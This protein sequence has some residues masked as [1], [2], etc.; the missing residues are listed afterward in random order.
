MQQSFAKY[1]PSLQFIVG[2]HQADSITLTTKQAASN[3]PWA[4]ALPHKLAAR[5]LD[6][7]RHIHFAS[8]LALTLDSGMG[9]GNPNQGK[10]HS[11]RAGDPVH[12]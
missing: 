6:H 1:C 12:S 11:D 5:H 10:R 9:H 2:Q 8:W 7:V 3:Q 4:F